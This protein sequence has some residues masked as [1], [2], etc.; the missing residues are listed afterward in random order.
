MKKSWSIVG[1]LFFILLSVSF[2]GFTWPDKKKGSTVVETEKVRHTNWQVSTCDVISKISEYLDKPSAEEKMK[3]YAQEQLGAESSYFDHPYSAKSKS[4]YIFEFTEDSESETIKKYNSL[5][6]E[7]KACYG[8]STKESKI[9]PM[10]MKGSSGGSA[11]FE[12]KDLSIAL[13]VIISPLLGNTVNV[14]IDKIR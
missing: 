7:L 8:N 2:I 13:I 14:E 12:N 3:Y 5:Y 9:Q 1:N 4:T 11:V 10:S 6:S